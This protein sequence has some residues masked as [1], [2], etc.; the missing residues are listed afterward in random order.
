MRD[1]RK[2]S[3]TSAAPEVPRQVQIGIAV[4]IALALLLRIALLNAGMFHYDEAVTAQ[5]LEHWFHTGEFQGETSGRYGFVLL[6]G[7]LYVPYAALTGNSA[8][9]IPRVTSALFGAGIV[10]MTALVAFLL[11]RRE[12]VAYGAG[13]LAL[14]NPLLLS[15]STI[16]KEHTVSTFFLLLSVA[17]F[18]CY[19]QRGAAWLLTLGSTAAMIAVSVREAAVL[20]APLLLGYGAYAILTR[21]RNSSDAQRGLPLEWAAL[22]LPAAL[23][24]IPLCPSVCPLIADALLGPDAQQSILFSAG[25]LPAVELHMLKVGVYDL[26]RSIT[27]IGMLLA[28]CGLYLWWR[29]RRAEAMLALLWLSTFFYFVSSAGYAARFFTELMPMFCI[30]IAL[31]LE[32]AGSE[33]RWVGALSV[34]AVLLLAQVLPLLVARHQH[35]GIREFSTTVAQVTEQNA[36]I[37]TA[38]DR[39]FIERY[40]TRKTLPYPISADEAVYRRWIAEMGQLGLEGTPTYLVSTKR[41]NTSALPDYDEYYYGGQIYSLL[42]SACTVT[43]IAE[44]TAENYH[45]AE[46]FPAGRPLTLERISC[47]KVSDLPR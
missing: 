46:L 38:D 21:M 11:F 42:T 6:N 5:S 20:F 43:A 45:H 4:L 27:P 25:Y 29:E 7:L 26:F 23:L 40:A 35:S 17:A 37:I 2:L 32:H 30:A 16:G 41:G 1:S 24:S 36:I 19:R 44:G 3:P 28:A 33:W 14:V 47:P 34:V 8:E 12:Q 15:Q 18:L 13:M 9:P 31:I 39:L 10:G 22:L